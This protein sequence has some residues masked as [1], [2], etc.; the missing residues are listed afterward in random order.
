MEP[1]E[2][3]IGEKSFA[4]KKVNVRSSHYCDEMSLLN[5]EYMNYSRDAEEVDLE[6]KIAVDAAEGTIE[7]AKARLRQLAG[8]KKIREKIKKNNERMVELREMIMAEIL[9]FNEYEYDAEYWD[10]NATVEEK[11]DLV[12]RAIGTGKKKVK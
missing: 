1:F 8:A 9:R 4:I 3:T 12:A 5:A 7:K 11:N 2:I 10:T 6:Y